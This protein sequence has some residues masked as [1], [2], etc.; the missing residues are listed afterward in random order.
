MVFGM[1]SGKS[2]PQ[3]DEEGHFYD[4]NISVAYDTGPADRSYISDPT[5]AEYDPGIDPNLQLRTVR[6]AAESIAESH[7]SEARRELRAKAK[8]K[9]SILGR[10]GRG[11]T[12][13]RRKESE[14]KKEGASGIAELVQDEL[15][16]IRQGYDSGGATGASGTGGEGVGV[17]FDS[18]QQYDTPDAATADL[19]AAKEE[20]DT[21]SPATPLD[22]GM[23]KGKKKPAK[24]RNVY[25]NIAPTSPNEVNRRGEP[26]VRYPRNKVRTSKYTVVTFLP[27][28]LVEQFRRLANIYFLGL[29][30]LQA[31]QMFGATVPQIA[32]LP[33]VSILT[34]TAIKDCV[35]DYR[36]HLLDNQV[37][38]S[39][40]TR[41]GSWRNVNQPTDSRSWFQ[42]LTGTGGSTKVSKGVKKLREKEDAIG[43]RPVGGS[44]EARAGE[45]Y[46]GGANVER[47]STTRTGRSD[48]LNSG[49]GNQLETI[50]SESEQATSFA[51]QSISRSGS[52]NALLGQSTPSFLPASR[53]SLPDT[54]GV[55][56]Y[57]R[58]TPGTGRWERTLW[59]KL[60]VGDVVLLREDEQVP[61]DVVLLNS[62]DPDG[63]AFVET[64]NL[65]GETNL[66]IKKCLKATMGIQTEEDVEHARFVIDSEPPHANLYSYSALLKFESSAPSE[67]DGSYQKP[68]QKLEP[69]TANELLLR[70]CA[71]RNTEW[72]IALVVFT[73]KDTKIMLNGGET[74]S[75]RSKIEKETNVNVAVNFVILLLMC[76]A[77]AIIGGLILNLDDTSRDFYEIGATDSS[78]NI[79]NALIIFG[80]CLV[81]YQNI[82]PISLYISI[83]LTKVR[84]PPLMR[85]GR[86]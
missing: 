38:N 24:R 77:C 75:K 41:L 1:H 13:T 80:C 62:S 27:R 16:R 5:H 82:V 19:E 84:A 52:A 21:P 85:S 40:V 29:V 9:A 6:T 10:L 34:I 32:M 44:S 48:S 86:P 20:Y 14:R 69:V 4:P 76:S 39:A 50:A 11:R 26:L 42:K 30:V 25:L 17:P 51:K 73:G 79:I 78:S 2:A 43:M 46:G 83:E 28:F 31:F 70:G 67:D 59:K 56:D 71:L 35:E 60:E 37:N 45:L 18:A 23:K 81:L 68:S 3:L 33:L 8:R 7:R 22:Q 55:V 58:H 54:E 12:L 72:I 15:G 49:F 57:R 65:D 47:M 74:P 66:K 53:A 61:A 63:N 64:K 36:R